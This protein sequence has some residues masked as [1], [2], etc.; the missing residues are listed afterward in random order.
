VVATSRAAAKVV[1]N[2]YDMLAKAYA[3]APE[4]FR[5][6]AV[7]RIPLG[8]DVAEMRPPE[9]R[10]RQS[11][12]L[13]L[14]CGESETVLLIFGRLSHHSKMDLLP[15]FRAIQRIF[16]REVDPSGL[17][18]LLAG[19]GQE[20]RMLNVYREVARNI[21]LNLTIRLRPDEAEKRELFAAADVFVSPVDNPQETFGIA[22][23]EAGAFGLPAVASDY[24]GYRD[25]V[26]HGETGFLA[27]VRGVSTTDG[28]NA[29][30]PLA[31]DTATH[32]R[33]AQRTA[34]DVSAL[35]EGLLALVR[36]PELGRVMGRAARRRVEADFS[37]AAVVEKHLALW[38]DL[39][40]RPVDPEAASHWRHPQMIDYAEVF[41]G[42]PSRALGVDEVLVA[43]RTGNAVHRGR[44]N[45]L[46]HEGLGRDVSIRAIKRL[47][48]EARKPRPAGELIG[49]LDKDLGLGAE[50]A[51]ANAL[52]AL[53]HDL[54]E[55]VTDRET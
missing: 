11:A 53:K 55:V 45:V 46:I 38:D 21:G 1:D 51:E 40:S 4:V 54:L 31:F 20:E 50:S 39:W 49:V 12:R 37:W 6:P 47:L 15:L 29:E 28:V 10:E 23:L 14:G 19:W 52:W 27:P 33:L 24:D 18:L 35:A 34:V 8:V 41:A 44:D 13:K 25:I 30:A 43:T 42:H 9:P 48:F 32:L 36:D 17:R 2:Y 16:S 26:V 22:M 3:L 7:E 5:R